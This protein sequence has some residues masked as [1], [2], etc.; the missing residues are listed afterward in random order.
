MLN[1]TQAILG[2]KTDA[3]S[4]LTTLQNGIEGLMK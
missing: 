2:G 1:F 3:K 4:A